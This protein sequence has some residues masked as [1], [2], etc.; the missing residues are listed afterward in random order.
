MSNKELVDRLIHFD[1]WSSTI[2]DTCD[3]NP[4]DAFEQG[5]RYVKEEAERLLHEDEDGQRGL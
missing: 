5:A 2:N 4:A 3:S 1:P